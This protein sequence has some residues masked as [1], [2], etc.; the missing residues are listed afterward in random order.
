MK[1]FS[2]SAASFGIV[3]SLAHI[4]YFVFCFFIV[5]I[6][7]SMKYLLFHCIWFLTFLKIYANPFQ[8]F[9]G[10][11][12]FSLL[13][14]KSSLGYSQYHS[15]IRYIVCKYFCHSSGCLFTLMSNILIWFVSLIVHIS[16][17]INFSSLSF[18]EIWHSK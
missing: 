13:S 18:L 10:L 14:C 9:I 16:S 3:T 17:L 12:V 1:L 8:I 15:V 5:A 2:K 11:F 6:L 4:H 7:V